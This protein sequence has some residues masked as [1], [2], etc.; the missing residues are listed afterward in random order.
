MKANRQRGFT[1]IEILVVLAILA[2]TMTVLLPRMFRSSGTNVR[3][4]TRNFIVLGKEVRNRAR[5]A[6]AT[7][8]LVIDLNPA[9]PKY[10]V[11]KANGPQLVDPNAAEKTEYEKE[12]EKEKASPWEMDKVLTKTEKELPSGLYFASV[13]TEHMESPQT[14]GVAYVHFFP[15]GLMQATAIQ[16]T[17]RKNLTW[18]LLFNPLTGQADIAEE[19]KSLK[20]LTR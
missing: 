4:V 12:M 9:N 7:M 5:V 15:E 20:D 3:E 6:N 11:E 13:E 8:R 19:A 16:I 18:T 1:L 14:E 10:W 17:D 2:A